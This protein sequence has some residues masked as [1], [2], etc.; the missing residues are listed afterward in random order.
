LTEIGQRHEGKVLLVLTV[1]IGAVIG[2]VVV[3]F[4]LVTEN[5]GARMYPAGA[6]AWRRFAVPV[7]GSLAAG[8]LLWRYFP[9]ARGSGIPQTKVALFLNNGI[10]PFRTAVGKFICCATTLASGIA[11]GREGPSVHI[12]AGI[13]STLGRRLGLSP[14]SIRALIPI[15]AAAA[16]AAAFNTPIAGVFF[17]LEEIV[18]DLNAPLLGSIA[19]SSA[20]SWTVLHLLLGDEPLFHVPAYELIHPVEFVFY[21]VLGVAGGFVSVAFVKLLLGLRRRFQRLPKSTIWIQPVAGG[22]LMG[23][24]GWKVPEVLGVGYAY[25]GKAL[26]GEMLLT[27][28]ALL[29]LLKVVATATSYASGNSGGIFGPTLFIGGMLGGAFGG[30]VHL[31]LPD[32]TGSVG[33]YALVG[34]GT[35]FAGVVRTPL[36]SVIMIFEVTRDYTIVVPLMISNLIAYFIACRYQEDPTYE[37]LLH[38]DGIY[39]PAG[40]RE[41]EEQ[42][43]VGLGS[44]QPSTV[45]SAGET[46][47]AAFARVNPEDE[48][49]PV[50]DE[51]GLLGM[52]T[53]AQLGQTLAV[54]LDREAVE[55]LLDPGAAGAQSIFAD[56]SLD[57]AMRRMA[58][59]GLK[60]LPVVSRTDLRQLTGVVTLHGILAAYGVEKNGPRPPA[61][62]EPAPSRVT[63]LTRI[64]IALALAI[65]LAGFLA[66]YY[67]SERQ[68]RAI[69]QFQQ[70]TVL[71]ESGRY[72][73]AVSKFRSALSISHSEEIRLAL[74]RAL[75][76]A[77]HLEE[78]EIAF[79]SL[80]RARPNSGPVNLGMARLAVKRD[81]PQQAVRDYHRAIYG[82]WQGSSAEGRF[83]A[84]KEL[85]DI[86]TRLNESE[87]ARAEL[88][89]WKT[90]APSDPG[91]YAGLGEANLTSGDFAGAQRA[92]REAVRLA[93]SNPDYRERLQLVDDIVAMDPS[94]RGL[95]SAERI[96]R[97]LALLRATI[98]ASNRC[99]AGRSGVDDVLSMSNRAERRLRSA[100]AHEAA[101]A[102]VTMAVQLWETRS[103]VCG[104]AA[105]GEEALGRVMAQLSR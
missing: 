97:S 103:G 75:T 37:A 14:R 78:A 93:P 89:A 67:R 7:A 71:E 50:V 15:S 12:A 44:R 25:V 68:G 55:A 2:L 60:A 18:G 95:S 99:V 65:G 8:F 22:L 4:I 11:L 21:A 73:D 39:L 58:E 32:Y 40:A 36:T 82:A 45:L 56:D 90:E 101:E 66:Y 51:R 87:Q 83:Q 26:N 85:I 94:L 74:A 17:S 63:S 1:M 3:A 24:L 84:R 29:V 34:M 61:P 20:T 104:E 64:A 100:T 69:R 9:E 57:T 6:A 5:L 72:E 96:R 41:R 70:G 42:L 43:V 88:M 91:P 53:A 98:D 13:G 46:V 48:A 47:A 86:L 81:N 62:A 35:A 38:Q 33:A 79:D 92:F 77:G 105:A 28:M 54:G 30:A 80:L 19:L 27:T 52:V 10:V 76:A 49:W 31:L 59:T 16:L 102:N 23:I